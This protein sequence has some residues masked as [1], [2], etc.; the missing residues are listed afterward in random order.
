MFEK[1]QIL[2][3]ENTQAFDDEA[4]KVKE[5]MKNKTYSKQNL[6]DL[7]LTLKNRKT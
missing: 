3:L 1:A 4:T 5:S 7:I 6:K 2:L